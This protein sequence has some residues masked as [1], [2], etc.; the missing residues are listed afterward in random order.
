MSID[1]DP[2]THFGG[3]FKTLYIGNY[4]SNGEI[5]MGDFP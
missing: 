2:R 4:K 5:S 3:S 1:P